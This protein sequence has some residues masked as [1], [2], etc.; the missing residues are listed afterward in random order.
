[1]P[2]TFDR[3]LVAAAQIGTILDNGRPA[4]FVPGWTPAF[5]YFG[6]H[7]VVVLVF[8]HDDGRQASWY[9]DE[10]LERRGGSVAELSPELRRSLMEAAALLFDGLWHKIMQTAV[11]PPLD[12][13]EAGFFKV[14][15][16][17]R[18]EIL[19]CYLNGF[20]AG[21]RFAAVDALD[22]ERPDSQ[23]VDLGARR[24]PLQR[25]H[26]HALFNPGGLQAQNHALIEHGRMSF[27]SPVDGRPMTVRHALV[28]HGTIYAYRTVEEATGTVMFLVAG[29][30][31]FRLSG[32]FIPEGRICV[33]LHRDAIRAQMPDMF[34][35]F[36]ARIMQHGDLLARYFANDRTVPL[37]AW[38]GVTAMHIGHVLWNDLSGIG[39]IVNAN[40]PMT[41]PRF[42]LFDCEMEPEMYGPLD[43]IFPEL[44][45]LVDRSA[46]G[47]QESIPSFYSNGQC[48]IRS[49][50]MTV[51]K[52]VRTRILGTVRPLDRAS[53]ASICALA[54]ADNVPVVLFGIR[55]ENRTMVNLEAFCTAL[56]DRL[57]RTLGEAVLVVDGHN[58]RIGAS[59]SFIWSHGEHGAK[60]RPIEVER[61]MVDAM[62]ERAQGTGIEIVSTIGMPITESLACGREAS[63]MVAIWGAGLAKYRWV[64][65]LPGLV[66]TNHWN[67]S[68]LGD[69]H[70]YDSALNMEE[71]TAVQFIAP[72]AV[73]DLPDAPLL[74]PLGSGFIPSIC[75]FR[76][77]EEKAMGAVDAMLRER[78]PVTTS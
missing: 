66:I 74:V 71:P 3:V 49:S 28:L 40:K 64:C 1:M 65:N 73:E 41:L 19:S 34:R 35:E 21:T 50:A 36:F 17:T 75:N 57:S 42:A 33:A 32:L 26:L 37:H 78:I 9:L 2:L 55:V 52:S 18:A 5:A 25:S 54:R 48:L 24:L 56:V 4:V 47:F 77:D 59:D 63:A 60:R 76:I 15:E 51:T 72:D 39:N 6:L 29:E 12:A 27:P 46:K 61:D 20:D 53:P 14:P 11:P 7:P 62:L 8:R 13:R 69:L 67:L 70:I 23:L 68:N 43:A 30:I 58:S 31:F 38:R 16:A 22:P 44:K 45:G 10:K